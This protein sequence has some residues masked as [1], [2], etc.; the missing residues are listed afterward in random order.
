[1]RTYSPATGAFNIAA[2]DNIELT[3][4]EFAELFAGQAAG[5]R[6]VT[7]AD[8]KPVLAEQE[9]LT[10]TQID[11]LRYTAYADERSGSD[12]LFAE[13]SRMRLMNET[14]AD[15]ALAV[16]V[17]RFDEIQAAYPWTESK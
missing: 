7:G 1:M 11:R 4:G 15:E 12:R 8:G 10:R 2:E 3:S 6:I 9:P 5:S 13:A 16:A 17:A 14:G